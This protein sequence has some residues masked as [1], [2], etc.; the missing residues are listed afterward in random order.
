MTPQVRLASGELKE[1]S[2]IKISL[3]HPVRSVM[4]LCLKLSTQNAVLP[5]LLAL[6]IHSKEAEGQEHDRED[7]KLLQVFME[8][9]LPYIHFFCSGF[10]FKKLCYGCSEVNGKMLQH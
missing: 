10:L 8:S 1:M 7:Y 3:K 6:V 2:D 9:S 5:V 4:E